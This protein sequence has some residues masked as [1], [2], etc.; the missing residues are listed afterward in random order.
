MTGPLRESVSVRAGVEQAD[1]L[2]LEAKACF[3]GGFMGGMGG[4]NGGMITEAVEDLSAQEALCVL[5]EKWVAEAVLQ[6][7]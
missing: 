1:F 6:G 3:L 4:T 2:F 7:G 5:V